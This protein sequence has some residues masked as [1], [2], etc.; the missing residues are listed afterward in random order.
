MIQSFE[1][2]LLIL[3][4]W[5]F[6]LFKSA[7]PYL[8]GKGSQSWK[9]IKGVV[10]LSSI[11]RAGNDYCPKIIYR[12]TYNGKEYIN[13]TYTFLG[14]TSF[15]KKKAINTAQKYKTGE[16]ITVFI[17]PNNPS[18]SVLVPG[19]HFF[20]YLALIGIT[21]LFLGAAFIVEI[22]NFIWPGCQPNCK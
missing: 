6:L 2:K 17:N 21:M 16:A 20:Q 5:G 12:Y 4:A 22:L 8:L 14:T 11:D 1:L 3:G 18:I 15:S 10:D 19:V 7:K 9:K 13:D